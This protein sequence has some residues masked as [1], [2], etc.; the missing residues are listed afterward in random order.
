MFGNRDESVIEKANEFIID[1]ANPRLHLSF[2]CG[3]P[4]CMGNRL[5]EM[6]L[7]IVWEE[8]LKRYRDVEVVG[9]SKRVLSNFV[10]GIECMPVVLHK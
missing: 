8:I 1:R 9:N 10:R 3:A 2:G 6:Q 4:R 5:G 7:H